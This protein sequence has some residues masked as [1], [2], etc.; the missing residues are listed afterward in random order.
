VKLKR[1]HF[2]AGLIGLAAFLAT[3]QYMDRSLAH[4]QG[5]QDGPRA[6]YRSGHIYIL[7]SALL[8]LLLGAYLTASTTKGGRAVQYVGSAMLLGALAFFLYGF[9]VETPL[10]V[11]ERPM[12]RKG[13]VWS[14]AGVIAHAAAIM[15]APKLNEE[16]AIHEED[17]IA[18]A[19]PGPAGRL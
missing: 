16:G 12:V 1:V 18:V 2:V 19:A 3:G 5:M 11:I 4:L 7:F 9:A 10:A 13:I 8:N 14:L 17:R 15:L 6:L